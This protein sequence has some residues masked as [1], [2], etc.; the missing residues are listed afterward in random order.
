M[1]K[2]SFPDRAIVFCGI[3]YNEKVNLK[4]VED[5]I[6]KYY[7][8]IIFK[9]DIFEFTETSY[10]DDEIGKPIYRVFYAINKLIEQD[11]IIELKLLSN[12]LEDEYFSDFGRRKVNID[13]GYLTKAKVVLPTTK[14]FQHRIYLGRGIYA[15]V[16]LRWRRGNFGEWEWTFK[17]YKRKE[18]INFFNRL[19][20]YY[21]NLNLR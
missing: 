14:N 2:I 6:Q 20:E 11:K 21:A 5:I 12:K 19:R 17:D 4:D 7:G 9:S 13:P 8:S 18:S 16:T 1:G 15:E 3:L 10:Y